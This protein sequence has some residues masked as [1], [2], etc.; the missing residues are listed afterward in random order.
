M[1]AKLVR[2]LSQRSSSLIFKR[3]VLMVETKLHKVALKIEV[4]VKRRLTW[5]RIRAFLAAYVTRS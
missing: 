4:N 3:Y 1:M 5:L 2:N